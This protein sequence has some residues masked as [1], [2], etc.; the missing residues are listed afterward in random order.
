MLARA[1]YL[2][3]RG[4]LVCAAYWFVEVY[5]IV[6]DLRIKDPGALLLLWGLATQVSKHVV[7]CD[8][9]KIA[10]RFVLSLVVWPPR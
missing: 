6:L 10:V 9:W 2:A 7:E 8:R 4:M 3:W 5:S 1:I